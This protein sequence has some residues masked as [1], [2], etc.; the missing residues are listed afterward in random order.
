MRTRAVAEAVLEL[1]GRPL[2]LLDD[3]RQARALSAEGFEAASVLE[4]PGWAWE[5]AS[6]AWLD[7]FVDWSAELQALERAGTPAWLVENRCTAERERASFVVQP[8]LYV[9]PDPWEVEHA[10]RVLRGPAWIPLLAS[11]RG[12]PRPERRDI[13]LLITFGGVDP[14]RSTERVLELLGAGPAP[15]VAVSVGWHM[16]AGRAAIE[17]AAGRIGARVLETGAALG[18]WMARSRVAITALGTTL[19]ELAHLRTHGLILANFVQDRAVLDFYREHG[20]FRPLGLAGE[21]EP[22][23]LAAGIEQ[24]LQRLREPAAPIPGLGDGARRIAR[25]L[26]GLGIDAEAA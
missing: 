8:K 18:P 3:E 4:R 2:L 16:A 14:L 13:D 6:G 22:D 7:G 5:R 25:G 11:V 20:Y 17:R 9:D 12:T 19:F 10:G 1:G 24:A 15:A 21:I 26:L 23:A